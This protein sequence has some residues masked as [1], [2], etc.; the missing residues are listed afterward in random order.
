MAVDW[1]SRDD[2]PARSVYNDRPLVT[3]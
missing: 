2:K 3:V 1:A